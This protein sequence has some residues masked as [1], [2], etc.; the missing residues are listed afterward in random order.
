MNFS[1]EIHCLE[2]GKYLPKNSNLLSLSPFLDDNKELR[3]R[4]RLKNVHLSE[5]EKHPISFSSNHNVTKIIIG[6]N[7]CDKNHS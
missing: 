3:I 7:Q 5:N 6:H 1:K 2:K 4:G